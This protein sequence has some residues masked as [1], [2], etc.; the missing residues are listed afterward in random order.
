MDNRPWVANYTGAHYPCGRG[1]DHHIGKSQ[2]SDTTP[3]PPPLTEQRIREIVQEELAKVRESG[4]W[5]GK[6]W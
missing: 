1:I 2:V 6:T 4:S 5:T 3:T